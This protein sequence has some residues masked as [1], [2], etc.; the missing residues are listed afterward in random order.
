MKYIITE[1]QFERL[2]KDKINRGKYGKLIERLIT[3]YM[4][5]SNICDIAAMVSDSRED[6]Y[7]VVVLSNGYVNHNLSGKLHRY[8]KNFLPIDVFINIDERT[9]NPHASY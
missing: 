4:G 2:K 5:E 7:L 1:S 3:E 8:I 9:C 6:F